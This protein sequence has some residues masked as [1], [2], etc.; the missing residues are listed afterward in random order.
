MR[1]HQGTW[2]GSLS[3]IPDAPCKGKLALSCKIGYISSP[4][5]PPPPPPDFPD[6]GCP[7]PPGHC[8]ALLVAGRRGHPSSDTKGHAQL[9]HASLPAVRCPRGDFR[10]FWVSR[11]PRSCLTSQPPP[12]SSLLASGRQA[13]ALHTSLSSPG[14]ALPQRGHRSLSPT[15]SVLGMW[16]QQ[17]SAVAQNWNPFQIS[18]QIPRLAKLTAGPASRPQG[19]LSWPSVSLVSACCRVPGPPSHPASDSSPLPS[20]DPAR[21]IFT[22]PGPILF[23]SLSST[24]FHKAADLP[25]ALKSSPR[26][27]SSNLLSQT[28]GQFSL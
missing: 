9:P 14:P 19:V 23:L 7:A 5:P 28:K 16:A 17:R 3:P 2:Q 20:Q 21:A 26:S 22:C 10:G 25:F 6:P 12:S 1:T 27:G 18:R 8:N 4:P 13:A 11:C 24:F 15:R